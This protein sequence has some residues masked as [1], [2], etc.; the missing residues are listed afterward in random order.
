MTG[1]KNE[2]VLTLPRMTGR[3]RPGAGPATTA[4]ERWLLRR[5]H[6]LLGNPS[7]CFALWDG[8]RVPEGPPATAAVATM[9]IGDRRSLWRLFRNPALNFGDDYSNGLI[10]IEGDLVDFVAALLRAVY[11]DRRPGLTA[12]LLVNRPTWRRRNTLRESRDNIHHHYDL[13]NDFY[14]LWLDEEM[15]YTCAYFPDPSVSLEAAQIAKMDHVCAKLQLRGGETVV[16]AGCGWGAL[17]LHMARHYGARV[18]AFNISREQIEFA[19]ARARRDGLDSLV[20]FVEDDYRNIRGAY[21]VF[22]SVGM[23]E[24]VG[25]GFHG[26]FARAIDRGLG[27]DGRGL[28]HSIAQAQS[29]PINPWLERRIF[30]G[31]YPPTLREM[32]AILEPIHCTVTDVE[33]L[34]QHYAL[35]LRHWLARFDA[36]AEEIRARYGEA[37]VRAWRLYLSGSIANFSTNC[38]A[39]YQVLFTRVARTETPWTRA[40]LYGSDRP[41]SPPSV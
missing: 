6:R 19:R 11:I 37:F 27:R 13:G 4:V 34:R 33:N 9:R 5:L 7:F 24:H 1:E 40:Y 35:T 28:V 14:R 22:V 16:E 30:P 39:L 10:E 17:S 2:G 36:H 32:A 25:R 20:T 23:L 8:Y 12:R 21:D 26:D 41:P 18:T 31:G 38:L 3:S 15:V 29:F